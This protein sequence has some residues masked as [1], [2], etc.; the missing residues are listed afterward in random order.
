MSIF[1][2]LWDDAK[3]GAGDVIDDGAHLAGDGWTLSG[4]LGRWRRLMVL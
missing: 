4:T 3:R 2:E 1:G